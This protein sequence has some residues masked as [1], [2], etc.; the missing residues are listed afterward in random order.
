[1]ATFTW[2]AAGDSLRVIGLISGTS[3]DGIDAVLAEVSRRGDG[4]GVRTLAT[5][6][7]AYT[8]AERDRVLMLCRPDAPLDAVCAANFDLAE[9]FAGA[10][11]SVLRAAGANPDDCDL[12][13]SHGQTIWHIPGHSTLQIG[14]GA[15]IAERTGLPV[16]SNFRARDM[17]AGGGGAPLVSYVDYLLFR[18]GRL[19]RAAQNLGG[20]GNVTWIPAGAAPDDVISF[21]TGPANMLIDG[22][23]QLMFAQPFD[24]DGAIAAGGQV[25]EQLLTQL[26]ADPYY[27]QGPPKTT[28]REK[29][30]VAFAEDIIRRWGPRVAPADLV[31]TATML[32]VRTVARAYRSFLPGIDEI[33][34][35]GGG[36][37][38]ATLVAALGEALAPVPVSTTA[39]FGVDPDFKEAIA[40]AVLGAETA[41]GAPGNLPSATGAHRRVILGD[42]TPP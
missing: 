33:I 41:W 32:T 18:D 38:N 40:F 17:A 36:V 14:A 42:L 15:V 27:A 1:M 8:A 31:A 13:A 19:G 26:L 28:G 29:Y 34:L 4:I 5:F 6:S 12:I 21:D 20:I 24:N 2:P 30:G 35:S 23:A 10:A 11:L 7:R 37:H 9:W 22:M 16:V 25:D 3:A 39:A